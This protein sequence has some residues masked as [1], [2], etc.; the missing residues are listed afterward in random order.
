[1][2]RLARAVRS[3][4]ENLIGAKAQCCA[5]LR[6]QVSW[7]GAAILL[8]PCL[9]CLLAFSVIGLNHVQRPLSVLLSYSFHCG[10]AQRPR[11]ETTVKGM[12]IGPFMPS[13]RPS[14][15]NR[16]PGTADSRFLPPLM[17]LLSSWFAQLQPTL[18][19][20]ATKPGTNCRSLPLYTQPV[21]NALHGLRGSGCVTP[22]SGLL[23]LSPEAHAMPCRPRC[24]SHL[25]WSS[26]QRC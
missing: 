10:F 3:I 24:P 6:F 12:P 11:Q 1:M 8:S 21:A 9:S 17:N 20:Q 14:R 26:S 2:R 15:T 22:P 18:V 13:L 4:Q 7:A 23:A 5:V 16:G 25:C 19:S